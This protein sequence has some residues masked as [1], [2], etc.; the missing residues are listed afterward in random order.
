MSRAKGEINVRLME[1]RE[2]KL[3]GM[4]ESVA[5]GIQGRKRGPPWWHI[6]RSGEKGTIEDRSRRRVISRT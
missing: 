2:I 1:P 6:P 5:R 3:A 4:V